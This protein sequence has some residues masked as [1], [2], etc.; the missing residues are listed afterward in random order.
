[1]RRVETVAFI[2]ILGALIG[3]GTSIATTWLV[4]RSQAHRELAQRAYDEQHRWTKDKREIFRDLHVSAN[5]WTHLLRRI[6]RG[7]DVPAADLRAVERSFHGLLYEAALLAGVEVCA[8]VDEAENE[9]LRLTA[10]LGRPTEYGAAAPDTAVQDA[11]AGEDFPALRDI[12]VRLMAAMRRELS[13][14]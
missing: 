3:A 14:G 9:L 12:R 10:A 7:E 5:H 11:V 1:M 8:L 4:Q 13:A 2:G 6:A